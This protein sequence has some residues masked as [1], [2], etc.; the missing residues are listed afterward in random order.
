MSQDDQIMSISAAELKQYIER[1]E[2]L[3]EEKATILEHIKEVFAEAKARGFD[4]KVMK[5]LM[6]IRK[7]KKEDLVLQEELLE[8]YRRALNEG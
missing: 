2:N 5:Q 3:E 7:M 1:A 6:K 4:V 8:L